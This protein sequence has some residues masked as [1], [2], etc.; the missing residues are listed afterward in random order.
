MGSQ[1]EPGNLET[2][3][4]VLAET[5]S[6]D[7]GD[8][9]LNRRLELML[10]RLADQPEKSIPVALRGWS[11]TQAAYRFF[12]NEK[13][14][15]EKV[16]SPHREATLQRVRQHPVVL[17]VEDTS[18]LD[19]TSRVETE[20]LGP[21]NYELTRGIYLHPM[22]AV[23][24]ER[25][26]LGVLGFWRWVRD[27]SNHGGKDR[28][29]R[30]SRALEDK[31]SLRWVE[32][33]ETVCALQEEVG[34]T[35]LVYMADRESDLFELFEAAEANQA[36]W[37][38][39][40]SQNRAVQ[41]GGLLREKVGQSACL[42]QIEFDLPP[43]RGRS[44]RRVVQSL[45]TARV[46]LRPPYRPDKKLPPVEVT[47]IWAREENPPAGEDPIDWL[48]LSSLPAESFAEACEKIQWYLCRWQIEVY[49]HILKNGCKVEQLQ[50][51]SRQRIEVALALYLIVAWRVLYLTRLGRTVPD[52]SCEVAFSRPEWQAV[53]WVSHRRP[54]P[55]EPPRLQE[56]LSRVAGLGGYLARKGD[57]PPGP[58]T[59][60]IGLQRVRDFVIALEAREASR[61]V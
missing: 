50:L 7:L 3:D 23:T 44:P 1:A 19:F 40:A 5:W 11:E 17:C 56:I 30:L 24:P 13:V 8:E 31:E 15:A 16:L 60:W 59:I 52:V 32:G 42:G 41:G 26:C 12:D 10:R 43:G 51:Q 61:Y 53:Y 54:P 49:F 55:V 58:K 22:I 39:R 27:A 4:W 18:E 38:I 9:R 48:L 33:Y 28:Q 20:G 35:R 36:A 57:G 21:L 25:L 34:E 6:A 14:T 2:E 37:L 47:A 45:R 46:V 29:D